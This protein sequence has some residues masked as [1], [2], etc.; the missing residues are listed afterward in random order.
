MNVCSH[1]G[2]IWE[3][4]TD[5]PPRA[6]ATDTSPL[7]QLT[8]QNM[9]TRVGRRVCFQGTARDVAAV[10]GPHVDGANFLGYP[11]KVVTTTQFTCMIWKVRALWRALHGLHDRFCFKNTQLKEAV[12][13]IWNEKRETWPSKLSDE[14]RGVWVHSVTNLLRTALSR[15]KKPCVAGRHHDGCGTS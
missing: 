12:I 4:L 6:S 8:H 14:H 1:F 3:Q 13:I 10:L 7:V 9:T 11:E 2:S 5:A 15:S